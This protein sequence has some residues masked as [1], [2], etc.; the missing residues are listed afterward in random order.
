MVT[1]VCQKPCMPGVG[2]VWL[3]RPQC[4]VCV[5]RRHTHRKQAGFASCAQSTQA[6]KQIKVESQAQATFTRHL[7]LCDSQSAMDV[8]TKLLQQAAESKKVKPYLALGA[9]LHVEQNSASKKGA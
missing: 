3:P 5:R 9:A 7:S 4:R 6:A 1:T 2:T 8:A